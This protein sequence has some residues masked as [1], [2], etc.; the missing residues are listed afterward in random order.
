MKARVILILTVLI[1]AGCTANYY[2][3]PSDFIKEVA[4][5]QNKTEK[6]V[7]VGTVQF[8]FPIRYDANN[9]KKI[10]CRDKNGKLVYLIPDG[11]TQLEITTRSTKDVVKM[12]FDTV[13]FEGSKLVGLRSRI[14]PGMNRE[15]ELSDID[16]IVIYAEFP[17]IK[18][19]DLK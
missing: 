14:V 7:L 6:F 3:Q 18:E 5:N 19:V 9:L 2:V 10:K 12:Y 4:A 11:N 15:I 17:R 1:I 16:S 13:F 8:F